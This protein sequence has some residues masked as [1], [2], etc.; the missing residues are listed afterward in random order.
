VKLLLDEM[1]SP[2]IAVEL[3]R[4]GVDVAAIAEADQADRYAGVEDDRVFAR[5]QEDGRTIVTDNVADYERARREWEAR[6]LSHRGVVYALNPPFNRHRSGSVVGQM[7]R[8][9]GRLVRS[10]ESTGEP[11]SGVHYLRL[12]DP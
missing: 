7:V 10:C 9:L 3:R 8:A 5:A 12:V 6:G 2:A 1:W 11:F 4:R